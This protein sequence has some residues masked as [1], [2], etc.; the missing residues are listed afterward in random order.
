MS[1]T[2]Q[3]PWFLLLLPLAVAVRYFPRRTPWNLHLL[4]RAALLALIVIALAQPVV[5]VRS[6]ATA[7]QV[8]VLDSSASLSPEAREALGE[9]LRDWRERIDAPAR[10]AIVCLGSELPSE[11]DGL[12]TI[13]LGAA[14][15]NSTSA[16]GTALETALRQIP[17]G[18]TGALTVITDGLATDRHWGPAM[19]ELIG[20]GIPVKIVDLGRDTRAVRPV[21][22][23]APPLLRVGQTAALTVDI[24]GDAPRLVVRLN[25]RSGR[26]LARSAVVPCPG[27]TSVTL[28]FEPAA[29]GFLETTIDV[30]DADTQRPA[31]ANASLTRTLAV[32]SPLRLLYLGGRVTHGAAR[33]GE[34]LGPGF[35]VTDA[36]S[37]TR[38]TAPDFASYDLVALD[39][40]PTADL[41]A[42]FQTQLARA[43]RRDGVGLLY[44]GGR[45]AFG[46]GGFAGTPIA[47]LLPVEIVQR[48][49]KQDPSTSLVLIVDT[50]GSM[51]G[52]RMDLAKQVARLAMRSLKAHDRIGIV[53]FYGNKHW[54]LPIQSAANKVAIERAIGRMQATGGTVLYPAIEEAYYGLKN[55]TTRFKHI[56]V[57]TDAG[58]ESADYESLLR[59][60]AR[61]GINV[62]TV[63]VGGQA[64]SGSLLDM[65]NWGGGRFYPVADRYALPEI[66]L[67]QTS[68]SELPA[69]REG[70]FALQA[71][72]G[73]TW[74]SDLDAG[75]I[76][77]LA[78]YVETQLRPG[79]E[80]L[81]A[82]TDAAHPVLAT[83]PVGTGRVTA[84]M[85]EPL[86]AGAR[87]WQ[88]WPDYGR[89]LAR[90]AS[91]T[92]GDAAPFAFSCERRGDVV[93]L[94][95]ER[96]SSDDTLR[97]DG[98]QLDESGRSATPLAFER[99]APDRFEARV[100]L[101]NAS[102]FRARV[103]ALDAARRPRGPETLLV[104]D[105]RADVAP[106]FQVDPARALDLRRLAAV[107]GGTYQTLAAA[108]FGPLPRP[109][110][111]PAP[112]LLDLR[113]AAASL[114]LLVYLLE[115]AY[116]RWPRGE[117]SFF[118]RA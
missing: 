97:P 15:S 60:I 30:L 7:H 47:D 3:H 54:A 33:L 64:H 49:E 55:V 71:R 61:D 40:R 37:L 59:R 86:A 53:E 44:S 6:N 13:L 5:V 81:L 96:R 38:D 88:Q 100:P 4:L 16:L 67:K 63:L 20:R 115:I 74:W 98:T 52:S 28:E 31:S 79:A 24:V 80:T 17:H 65:A 50:S 105:A 109:M 42:E 110:P 39:D 25:E 1:L 51:A 101:A 75:R 36:A 69:Y 32:Q 18:A 35:A 112:R 83:W 107:T 117:R 85:T 34:L 2:F 90:I 91:R 78:G 113:F 29:A 70:S 92:A 94:V 95:A 82:T 76:P 22:F 14:E 68:T 26:E 21:R 62:S 72:G 89:W 56:L 118:R 43:V 10:A 73:R 8:L 84:L 12:R 106:E 103:H 27:R 19:Q 111:S 41:P 57:I 66:L 104:S 45:A 116:R 9:H 58:I 11:A 48:S 114:A 46:G 93:T 99:V 87:L 102:P 108:T 23:D 77:A